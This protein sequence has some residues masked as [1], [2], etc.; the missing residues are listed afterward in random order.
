MIIFENLWSVVLD[1]L[2]TGTFFWFHFRGNTGTGAEHPA[3]QLIFSLSATRWTGVTGSKD[4]IT[5]NRIK[6]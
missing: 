2:T 4:V 1:H 5:D 3:V 6:I